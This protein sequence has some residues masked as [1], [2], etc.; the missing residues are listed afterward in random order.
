MSREFVSL[1]VL[2]YAST[3]MHALFLNCYF[4][5]DPLNFEMNSWL[6]CWHY[7]TTKVYIAY[8]NSTALIECLTAIYTDISKEIRK[9]P[10]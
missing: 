7:M 8:Y 4:K 3:F 5:N 1:L 10:Y 9:I 6:N 2:L